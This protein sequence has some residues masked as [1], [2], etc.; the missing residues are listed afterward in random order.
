MEGINT[1]LLSMNQC[2]ASRGMDISPD[3]EAY[4]R[5]GIANVIKEI[6]P[7]VPVL[8]QAMHTSEQASSIGRFDVNVHDLSSNI[9]GIERRIGSLEKSSL[10]SFQHLCAT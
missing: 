5:D 9:D 8:K 3:L 7:Q 1:Q 10:Q 6:L 4:A 2:S